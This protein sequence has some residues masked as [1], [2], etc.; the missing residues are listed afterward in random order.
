MIKD[1]ILV[2]MCSRSGS[3]MLAG[4]F[5]EHNVWTG[6]VH[7]IQTY[8]NPTYENK[9][10][11]SYIKNKHG[12]PDYPIKPDKNFRDYLFNV[13]KPPEN[14]IWLWKGGVFVWPMWEGVFDNPKFLFPQRPRQ[15]I[16]E[17]LKR[18]GKTIDSYRIALT[19]RKLDY[20]DELYNKYGG[21]KVQSEELIKGNYKTLEEAFDYCGLS[22]D[23]R[24]ADKFIKPKY[25]HYK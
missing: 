10:I 12:Y 9:L 15:Y 23:F 3:S 20:I 13:V 22:F 2:L 19:Q 16:L 24:V 14:T 11:K 21:V 6:S 8:P 7:S 25:W 1:P 17:S 18:R 4:I 5:A